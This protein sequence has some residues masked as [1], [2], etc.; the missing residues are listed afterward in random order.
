MTTYG[1][2]VWKYDGKTLKTL[3]LKRVQKRFYLW[4]SIKTT[5]EQFGLELT[6]TAFTNKMEILL[7]SL[8]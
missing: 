1:N 6:M 5:K 7:K 3:K 8:K 4:L 2:G